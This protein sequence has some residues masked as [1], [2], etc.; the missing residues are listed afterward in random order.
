MDKKKIIG[1]AIAGIAILGGG[2]YYF[3]GGSSGEPIEINKNSFNKNQINKES[4]AE[5]KQINESITAVKS[6]IRDPND[7][8]AMLKSKYPSVLKDNPTITFNKKI[9]MFELVNGLQV[10]YISKDGKNI[11]QGHIYDLATGLDYTD[12]KLAEIA[13]IDTSTL[14]LNSSI[15]LINGDGSNVLYVFAYLDDNLKKYYNDTLANINN[16]TIYLFLQKA[17]YSQNDDQYIT[18]YKEKIYQW[19]YCSDNKER[20]FANYLKPGKFSPITNSIDNCQMYL[21]S[22][23]DLK[24]FDTY[25]IVYSPTVFTENGYRYK[26]IPEV[27]L[28]PLMVKKSATSN[29]S[30][31]PM[32]NN[33]NKA[34]NSSAPTNMANQMGQMVSTS[35]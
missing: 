31:S 33:Q 18:N 13:K 16:T 26:A 30:S 17:T 21:K 9:D 10:L 11:I 2:G 32:S 1:I 27:Q 25:K 14:P 15:K 19:V 6:N 3:F 12:A 22:Y 20:E 7:L 34:Q 23:N 29:N 35:K 5:K 24:I 4:N 28:K 8:L